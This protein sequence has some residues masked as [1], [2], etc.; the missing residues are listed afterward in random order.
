MSD[1][2]WKQL[3]NQ[4]VAFFRKPAVRKTGFIALK[5][6]Q[7]IFIIGI[8]SGF[9]AA[10]AAFGLMASIV[11]NEPIRSAE[12]IK[13]QVQTNIKTGFVYFH[14]GTPVGQ[15][16]S[17]EDRHMAE[18]K[19]IPQ[20]L[21]DAVIAIEDND[22]YEHIGIDFKSSLRAVKQWVFKEDVQTGGSTITQ[23]L[24][25][26][27]FLSLEKSL[28]RKLK[29]MLLAIRLER[30]LSKDEIM[31]AYLNKIPYGNGSSGSTL[32]GIKA[33]AKGIFGIDDL[34]A[35]NLAQ[36]AYL[37]GVPQQ[38]S[39]HSAFTSKGDFNEDGFNRALERSRLVLARMLE[40]NKITK[41]QYDEALAFD[42]KSSLAEKTEKAYT[43][44]PFL[45]METER[46][47]AMILARMMNPQLGENDPVPLHELEEAREL[48]LNNG[49]H[50]YTTIDKDIYDAMQAIA[51]NPDY[52]TPDDPVKGIE[53]VGAMLLNNS[54]GAI[55]GMIEGRDFYREQMNHATQAYRQPGSSMKPIAAFIPALEMGLIQP[56]SVI[57][58]V[59]IILPD[60][61]KK[62]HIPDNWDNKFH[63]LVTA[64]HAL[65]QSYNIPAIKLFLQVGIET[66]WDYA[67]RMG[68]N[69]IVEEDYHAQT[70]VIG[71]LNRGV[72]VEEITNAYSTI[73]NYGV[74]YDAYMIEKI[75]DSEGNIIYAHELKPQRVFSEETAYLITDMLRT[76]ITSG[77]ATDI[78]AK[79][80][81]YNKVAVSGKT[82]S[83]QGDADAWFVGYTPDLTLGV[84]VGYEQ[85]IH[86]LSVA[87]GGTRRAKDVW[88]YVMNAAYELKPEWFR[89]TEFERPDDIVEMTV[90]T[91]SGMLPNQLTIEAGKVTKD[92]F[93]RIHLPTQEDNVMVR[94]QTIRYN[95]IQ[96][97]P[98]PET[99]ADF[100]SEQVV[101]RREKPI[102]VLMKEL[103]EALEAQ[104]QAL[105]AQGL[106]VE[107]KSL[108]QYL[109]LDAHTEAP[110]EVDPRVDDGHNPTAPGSVTLKR[111]GNQVQI[112]FSPSPEEDVI[113]FR[114]YRSRSGSPFERAEGMIIFAGDET[115][116]TDTLPSSGT[117]GYYITAVDVAGKESVPSLAVY[118]D[119]TTRALSD[120]ELPSSPLNPDDHRDDQDQNSDMP[121]PPSAPD[122]L[123]ANSK[124]KAIQLVWKA[125]A[126]KGNVIHYV[127]Y[128]RS[129]ADGTY[130]K[131]GTTVNPEFIHYAVTRDNYYI[132]TAVNE[133]GESEPSEPVHFHLDS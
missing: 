27:V 76:V 16:R 128:H 71:G 80:K 74:F 123:E 6:V 118:S 98:R 94:M 25:R 48:L 38:P 110:T 124:G 109:P 32:Y 83:T 106:P 50:I 40:E 114:L 75:V 72:T 84:W 18:L 126:R 78:M 49:Y 116:F 24:A 47:A 42:L 59:P 69:S 26:R 41:E 112:A 52:F 79:F 39:N 67:K 10:G 14:D 46:Q 62:Y 36:I 61:Q 86:K 45:M 108:D 115:V 87:T 8:I 92:L 4:T 51:Q 99:P 89:R 3:V 91:V 93:N 33:A 43:T 1:R 56:A 85:P 68:I 7:W 77:T 63:G 22:F 65:N 82:G 119:G 34:H 88:A 127:V 130:T 120:M 57:D 53:Q 125:N 101:V 54:T 35:L 105:E 131:L 58:D 121:V 100:L 17:E 96:Y 15:L 13:A 19:D 60:G 9:V 70:G 11:K 111:N 12:Y 66:A 31:L 44:Y 122:G 132:V 28:D 29:E 23:Q 102:S 117:V 81:Y 73:P 97:I 133:A 95:G 37:A 113:G 55:L 5:T 107:Q 104:K 21:L 90:S 20:Q 103:E 129:E 2:Q 64:R 30:V